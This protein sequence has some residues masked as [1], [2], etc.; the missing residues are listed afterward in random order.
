MK[1]KRKGIGIDYVFI[2][3]I[4]GPKGR[5]KGIIYEIHEE[6]CKGKHKVRRKERQR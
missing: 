3:L 6:S 5:Q 1:H 2:P 4:Y